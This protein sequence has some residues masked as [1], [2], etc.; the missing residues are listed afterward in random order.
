MPERTINELEQRAFQLL[1]GE[2]SQPLQLANRVLNM[3]SRVWGLDSPGTLSKGRIVR[4]L[5]LQ[6]MQNDLRCCQLMAERGYPL[7]A[8]GQAAGVYE[9]WVNIAAIVDEPTAL[10]WLSH[11]KETTSF[12]SIRNLT[13][14]AFKTM[15]GNREKANL[16]YAQYQQLCMAKHLNPLVEGLRGFRVEDQGLQFQAGPDVSEIG[17][18]QAWFSLERAARFAFLGIAVFVHNDD[19]LQATEE[20][21][22]EL[23]SLFAEL[24]ILQEFSVKRWPKNYLS[25]E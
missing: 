18:A 12:G 8:A 20:L 5:L 10:H 17:I 14:R 4:T 1:A 23:V 2:L 13:E 6:R 15:I 24:E 16:L 9:G 22:T 21:R 7:Q 3:I 11:D 19:E 25:S